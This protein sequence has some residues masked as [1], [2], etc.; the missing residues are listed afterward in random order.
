MKLTRL[1]AIYAV[2]AIGFCIGLLAIPAFWINLY[3]AHADS[4]ATILLRLAGALMGGLGVM[5]W[6]GRN[7]EPSNSRNAMV[8]G[9]SVCNALAA[10]VAVQGALSGVYN[11]FAWGPVI[12]FSAFALAFVMV[13]GDGR[14]RSISL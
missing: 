3:G 9:L 1:L 13:Q 8:F 5:A 11:Q 12:T 6:M 14:P 4:Q 7:A 2:V 10:A